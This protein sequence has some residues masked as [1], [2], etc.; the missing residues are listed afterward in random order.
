MAQHRL[1][2]AVAIVVGQLHATHVER[3]RVRGDVIGVIDEVE[4]GVAIDEPADQPGA[5]R[6]VDVHPCTRR[7][8]H[9]STPSSSTSSRCTAACASSRS[10][11]GKKSRRRIRSSSRRSRASVRR[12]KP[13]PCAA[14]SASE[15]T[16]RYSAAMESAMRDA[17]TTL[18]AGRSWPARPHHGLA[19]GLEDL[20]GEPLELFLG[21]G[22]GR[23]RHEP[24]HELH[25]TEAAQLAPQ[26]DAGCR[27]LPRQPVG[28]E[29]PVD[30]RP[31]VARVVKPRLH[32]KSSRAQ[33]AA[34][35][36]DPPPGTLGRR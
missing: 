27:R 3:C 24:V 8:S 18:F 30:P 11:G 22:V 21:A 5:G 28:E 36:R 31:H 32:D 17:S 13:S 2:G 16:A 12:S 19:A 35:G 6:P 33:P 9:R 23:K 29:H 1:E 14:A 25:D 7:P 26:R 15:R 20:V 4:L 10:A 34:T